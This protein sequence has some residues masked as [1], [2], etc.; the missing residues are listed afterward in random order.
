MTGGLET[1][2]IVTKIVPRCFAQAIEKLLIGVRQRQVRMVFPQAGFIVLDLGILG[3]ERPGGPQL[4]DGLKLVATWQNPQSH[5]PYAVR[6]RQ[7]FQRKTE[8]VLSMQGI[9]EEHAAQTSV[10]EHDA[11]GNA[12]DGS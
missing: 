8:G 1:P 3:I 9:S 7:C 10:D 6:C 12:G 4:L 5:T 11:G 2:A